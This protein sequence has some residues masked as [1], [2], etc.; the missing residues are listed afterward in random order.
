MID[1]KIQYITEQGVVRS[2]ETYTSLSKFFK[3]VSILTNLHEVPDTFKV[4]FT[5]NYLLK[6][7]SL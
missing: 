3:E 2:S 5:E 4:C 1:L 7:K 6:F